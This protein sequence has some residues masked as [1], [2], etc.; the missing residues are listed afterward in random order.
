[1]LSFDLYLKKTLKLLKAF[2]FPSTLLQIAEICSSKFSGMSI[3]KMRNVTL[4]KG[5]LW[6]W[7]ARTYCGMTIMVWFLSKLIATSDA[8]SKLETKFSKFSKIEDVV[9]STYRLLTFSLRPFMRFCYEEV[10]WDAVKRFREV[11]QYRSCKL[12][13]F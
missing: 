4:V 12:F 6:L 13:I 2:N 11:H 5:L 8:H 10:M 7:W 3:S 9:L 1:M